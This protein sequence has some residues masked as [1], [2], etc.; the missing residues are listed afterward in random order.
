[1]L[2]KIYTLYNN[3]IEFIS[4]STDTDKSAWQKALKQEKMDWKQLI[5][6]NNNLDLE[7]LQI[8]FK[9]NQAIPYTILIDNNMKILT[10]S[11]GLSNE[12]E[13]KKLIGK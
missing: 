11:T 4:I 6:S 3:E 12:E 9:L 1:L 8:H 5:V 2:K 7:A 10:S 13:L